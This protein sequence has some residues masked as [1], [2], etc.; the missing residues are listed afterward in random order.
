MHILIIT[1][2]VTMAIVYTILY[3]FKDGRI[4]IGQ[5]F[6]YSVTVIL[7]FVLLIGIA[8]Y[9]ETNKQAEDQQQTA[10]ERQKNVVD[11]VQSRS[12]PSIPTTGKDKDKRVYVNSNYKLENDPEY[13]YAIAH[14]DKPSILPVLLMV[15]GIALILFTKYHLWRFI[16]Y[17][18]LKV[19]LF[20]VR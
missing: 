17:G 10:I 1:L 2:P 4:T 8:C 11:L 18:K 15:L 16:P 14:P 13:Q 6:A 5:V 3:F 19:F 20:R 9:H 7:A 12:Q